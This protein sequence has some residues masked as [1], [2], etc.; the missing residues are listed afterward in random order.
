MSKPAKGERIVR[1]KAHGVIREGK[2]FPEE[3]FRLDWTI[4][5]IH[6][7]QREHGRKDFVIR[8][9]TIEYKESKSTRK[10]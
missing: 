10:K 5:K 8:P 3:V 2:D 4:A 7:W 9:I 6:K 1:K